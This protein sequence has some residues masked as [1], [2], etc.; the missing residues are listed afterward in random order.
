MHI[1]GRKSWNEDQS[2]KMLSHN[3]YNEKW[4]TYVQSMEK[5]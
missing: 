2:L 1:P 4:S 3:E 5:L